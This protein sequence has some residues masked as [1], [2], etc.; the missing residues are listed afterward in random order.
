MDARAELG[1]DFMRGEL[2]PWKFSKSTT[3]KFIG[4]GIATIHVAAGR[5]GLL[6]RRV[7][8]V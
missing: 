7:A 2:P 5:L 6:L 8:G 4:G 3:A 1:E